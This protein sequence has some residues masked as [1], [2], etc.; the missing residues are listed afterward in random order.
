MRDHRSVKRLTFLLMVNVLVLGG[1]ALL[2]DRVASDE[3]SPDAVPPSVDLPQGSASPASS[4]NGPAEPATGSPPVATPS[5]S[6]A[7]RATASARPPIRSV[8]PRDPAGSGTLTGSLGFDAIEGGCAYL[9]SSDGTRY[10]V[11]YPNDWR[12]DPG[13]GRLLGPGGEEAR[14]GAI[15]SVRGSIVEDMASI[16]QVGLMF[17]ATEVIGIDG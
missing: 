3:P 8:E 7:D 15:V 16:C 9:E 2:R 14:A 10:Q 5:A 13:R 12:I 6:Q 17:R 1:C 4:P 11:L